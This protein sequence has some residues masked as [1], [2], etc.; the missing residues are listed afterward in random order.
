MTFEVTADIQLF[1]HSPFEIPF[2]TADGMIRETV[3]QG[4]NKEIIIT[5]MEVFNHHSLSSIDMTERKCRF[6][7]E[8]TELGRHLE[9]YSFYS[10][11]TCIVECAF[12]IHLKFCNCSNHFLA[13][14]GMC[15]RKL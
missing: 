13:K 1:L 6:S 10:F 8:R 14:E 3:L 15:T 12:N 4:W 5:A 7:N 11:S 2:L 9:L